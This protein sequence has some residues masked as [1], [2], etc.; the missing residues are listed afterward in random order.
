MASIDC[1][2]MTAKNCGGMRRHLD[3]TIR[4]KNEH[5]NRHINQSLTHLNSWIGCS[6]FFE[7]EKN[8][9]RNVA[10]IDEA[11]PPRRERADRNV[12]ISFWITCPAELAD[13]DQAFFES[14]YKFVE[15]FCKSKYGKSYACGMAVHRDEVH[16]YIDH[17]WKERTSLT[18]GHMWVTPYARWVDKRT[19]YGEDGKPLREAPDESGKK[20]KIIKED[21]IAEGL[22][23]KHFLNKSFLKDLQQEFDRHV[24]QEFG[25]HYMTGEKALHMSVED[26][27]RESGIAEAMLSSVE[28]E[29]DSL[30]VQV[31]ILDL[32]SK[33]RQTLV[34]SLNQAVEQAK[35]ELESAKNELVTETERVN[36][37]MQIHKQL[38]DPER[39]DPIEINTSKG[40]RQY[41]PLPKLMHDSKALEA[42]ISDLTIKRDEIVSQI[43]DG[44]S[45]AYKAVTEY[46]LGNPPDIDRHVVR[47]DA[48]EL[49]LSKDFKPQ[50]RSV[51]YDTVKGSVEL[52]VDDYPAAER[53]NLWQ[54]LVIEIQEIFNQISMKLRL[55]KD[56]AEKDV[57]D[58]ELKA[59]QIVEAAQAKANSMVEFAKTMPQRTIEAQLEAKEDKINKLLG[60][61]S[62][63]EL[64]DAQER[65]NAAM[66]S[67]KDYIGPEEERCIIERNS[68][69]LYSHIRR[70]IGNDDSKMNVIRDANVLKNALDKFAELERRPRSAE[71]VLKSIQES[72]DR[73]NAF[74]RGRSR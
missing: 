62:Q 73:A 39:T 38:N 12:N 16:D 24:Y 15:D 35:K 20:G 18:H 51:T 27:K 59:A 10:E 40:L 56:L 46:R 13:K 6:N 22:N 32:K 60:I 5:A 43:K 34:D 11:H 54:R 17:G 52:K 29:R 45:E 28:K 2:K 63:K 3:E 66:S 8:M 47:N 7:M 25:V 69:A 30:Q 36:T 61:V 23:A 26:L 9:Q 49:V 21:Y 53:I 4:E 58:S 68:E 42:Q 19:V 37:V 50:F 33:S 72:S 70:R 57:R 64:A 65:V 41:T 31:K 14:A 71:D 74:H 67:L 48:D 55:R 1:R 44:S